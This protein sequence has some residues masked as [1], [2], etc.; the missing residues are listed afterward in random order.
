MCYNTLVRNER[1][2]K[3]N[4]LQN[5]DYASDRLYFIT[6]CTHLKHEL[7]GRIKD[8]EMFLNSDGKII[9]YALE[10]IAMLY[11]G[12]SILSKIIMPNHVHMIIKLQ[13]STKSVS[14]I[15]SQF[16][17]AT[18]KKIGF[19]PWQKNFHDR[20]I[21]DEKEYKTIKH[22]IANNIKNW[23]EDMFYV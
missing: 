2:R 11:D 14:H 3:T 7:F 12:I 9:H 1:I 15:I 5:F 19:S 13:N 16:K 10:Q 20:I 17:G 8:G 22:Y 21:R 4:R 18:S 6:I 23:A